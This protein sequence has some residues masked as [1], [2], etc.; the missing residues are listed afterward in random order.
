MT[1]TVIAEAADVITLI[2]V[3]SCEPNRQAELVELLSHAT[4][5]VIRH[6]P[7]FVSANIHASLDGARVTNYAQWQT[8]RD[9]EQMLADP[10]CRAHMSAASAIGDAEPV[11][12]R[13]ASVH[14]R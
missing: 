9:F 13:V 7:G 5:E 4:S 8:V 1:E 3:F 10:A 12:Y 2:N 11:L 6:R 14:H